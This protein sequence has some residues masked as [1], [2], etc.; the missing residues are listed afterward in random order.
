[1]VALAGSRRGGA[2]Q[3]GAEGGH[4]SSRKTGCDVAPERRTIVSARA[5]PI[6]VQKP[7]EPLPGLPIKEQVHYT[8][9]QVGAPGG[10][11]ST[12]HSW[13]TKGGTRQKW[14]LRGWDYV[15]GYVR[16]GCVWGKG[17]AGVKLQSPAAEAKAG[18]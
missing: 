13:G 11:I 8:A 18:K 3:P 12:L 15:W 16:R 4:G 7:Q 2:S 1:M 6:K 10:R 5:R 14:Y 9:G 17:S